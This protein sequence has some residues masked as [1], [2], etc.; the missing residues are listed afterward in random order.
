MNSKKKERQSPAAQLATSGRTTKGPE[1][2][3]LKLDGYANWQDAAAA[4]VRA[5]RPPGGWPK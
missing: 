3:R 4:M 1:P 2:E 5:K